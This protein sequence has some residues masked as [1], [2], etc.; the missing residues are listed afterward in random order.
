[1]NNLFCSDLFKDFAANLLK[2]IKET[3]QVKE[4]KLQNILLRMLYKFEEHLIAIK[5]V[6]NTLSNYYKNTLINV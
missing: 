2:H 6:H 5:V 3:E 1:M 4:D